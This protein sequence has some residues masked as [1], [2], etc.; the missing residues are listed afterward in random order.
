MRSRSPLS[1]LGLALMFTFILT[2][3]CQVKPTPENVAAR[4]KALVARKEGIH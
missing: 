4:A 2:P 3:A 1:V